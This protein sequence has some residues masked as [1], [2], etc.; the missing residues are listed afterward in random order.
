MKAVLPKRLISLILIVIIISLTACNNKVSK[1]TTGKIINNAENEPV[2]LNYD[3][4]MTCIIKSIDKENMTIRLFDI[5][6]GNEHTLTYNGGTDIKDSYGTVISMKQVELG[7]I[8]DA[9]YKSEQNKLTRLYISSEAWEYPKVS[10]LIINRTE[11]YMKIANSKYKY[12]NKLVIIDN[13]NLIDLMDINSQDELTLRGIGKKIY[14]ITVTK[15]HGYIRL[16]NYDTFLDGTLYVGSSIIIP[17]VENMLIVAREGKYQFVIEKDNLQA[18]KNINIRRNQEVIIDMIEFEKEVVLTGKISFDISPNNAVLYINGVQTDYSKPVKLEYGTYKI[19]VELNGYIAYSG[20]LTVANDSE[21]ISIDLANSSSQKDSKYITNNNTNNSSNTNKDNNTNNT[22]NNENNSTNNN[23]NDEDNNKNDNPKDNENNNIDDNKNNNDTSNDDK[24][25]DEDYYIY[26][27]D[28]FGG[29]VE[30]DE[31]DIDDDNSDEDNNINNDNSDEDNNINDD[32]S[33]EDNDIDNND[34]DS[35]DNTDDN[36]PDED[37]NSSTNTITDGAIN[38]N[39]NVSNESSVEGTTSV[40]YEHAIF[41]RSPEGASLYLNGNLKGT[42]PFNMTKEV[43]VHTVTISKEGY[44][45]RSY[46]MEVLDNDQD[47]NWQFDELTPD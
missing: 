1:S 38:S 13:N 26:D 27:E 8:V 34:I 25:N 32:N 9:Y 22:N 31:D 46:T 40:D 11:S 19:L 33:D 39:T 30:K 29:D 5:D 17:V 2:K 4:K 15:G 43:G 23:N 7:E 36:N 35:N 20:T 14:S 10:N 12:D 24:T 3:K 44:I 37:T 45:T 18:M 47:I 21:N 42:I 16:K 6:S 41:V 28:E